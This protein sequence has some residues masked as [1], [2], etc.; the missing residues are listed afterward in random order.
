MTVVEAMKEV[1]CIKGLVGNLSSQ[2]EL[3]VVYYD[4]QS[5]IHLTKNQMFHERG[6]YINVNVFYYGCDYTGAVLIVDNLVDLMTKSV[7]T[8][9]FRYFFELNWC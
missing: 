4:S 3:T 9:K 7:S 2:Q 5:V 6:K 1:I 8:V